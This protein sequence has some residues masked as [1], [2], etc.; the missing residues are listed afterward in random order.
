[1]VRQDWSD[2]QT[3][4]WSTSGVFGK[5]KLRVEARNTGSSDREVNDKMSYWLNDANPLTSVDLQVDQ[6]YL[7]VAGPTINF[8]AVPGGTTNLYEYQFRVKGAAPSAGWAVLRDFDS[9]PTFQ[10]SSASYPGKNRFQVRARNQGTLDQEVK[11]STNIWVNSL[12]AITDIALSG[13]DSSVSWGETITFTMSFSGGDGS[14]YF[15]QELK[16]PGEGFSGNDYF[17]PSTTNSFDFKVGGMEPGTYRMRV[18]AINAATDKP[19][20]SNSVKFKVSENFDPSW[21]FGGEN[22]D[23]R[24]E[25]TIYECPCAIIGGCYNGGND[26]G[27]FGGGY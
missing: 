2:I 6:P 21:Q 23:S 12:N 15:A 10:I 17:R 20:K 24:Q 26:T 3:F 9:D 18:Q 13:S 19:V 27:V 14:F 11:D 25:C 5:Q 22:Y 4:V 7:I 1:M 16:N 8:S